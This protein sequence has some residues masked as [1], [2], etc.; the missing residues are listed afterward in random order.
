M[1]GI[2][3]DLNGQNGDIAETTVT[4]RTK[5]GVGPDEVASV[6]IYFPNGAFSKTPRG[7]AQVEGFAP[8][9]ALA[10]LD[11]V[12]TDG[13]TLK[14]RNLSPTFG[15]FGKATWVVAGG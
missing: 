5:F 6:A 12:D 3:P 10:W 4:G 1:T 13:A 14:V 15:I 11:D 8:T 9:G 2:T 7:V